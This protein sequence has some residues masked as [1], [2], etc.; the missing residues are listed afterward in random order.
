MK[1]TREPTR[2]MTIRRFPGL[3]TLRF[4][5]ALAVVIGHVPLNQGS[6]GL[7]NP[8][9]LALF[10]R[11][12]P[13]VS[14]FFALSGFLITY[15]LL[16]ERRLT[17]TVAVGRFYLRRVLRIWPLYFAVVGVGLMF[18]NIVLPVL[19]ISYP[20][21]YSIGTALALYTLF[22]PNLMN[23]LYTVGGIL[24]PLW[25]IG[26][27]EQFYLVWAPLARRVRD[28]LPAACWSVLIVSL[29]VHFANQIGL[30][31][32]VGWVPMFVGQL[33]FHFMA[34]GALWA[35]ALHRQPNRVLQV[36]IFANRHIQALLWLLLLD[37]CTVEL[38]PQ[39]PLFTELFQLALYGWLIVNVAANPA[40][41]IRLSHPLTEYLGR[42]SYGIYMLHMPAVYATSMLFLQTHW[43]RAHPALFFAAYYTS[44]F[45]LTCGLAAASY[46]FFELRFLRLKARF[47]PVPDVGG[48]SGLELALASRVVDPIPAASARLS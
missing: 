36:S 39:N 31:G 29:A 40:N 12:A 41:L 7:P 45:I 48:L 24:N 15:L 13:A 44:V 9:P 33:K 14:F 6:V 35:W 20:V 17:G 26:L 8:A 21:H 5:A 37:F 2:S 18:Y 19:G 3:D 16:E 25:S 32:T 42:I 28:R 11:G 46:H 38:L 27:E 4:L 23:S 47:S 30:F 1:S 43:W 34:S 10:Y 22:L